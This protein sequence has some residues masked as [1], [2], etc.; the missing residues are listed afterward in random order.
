MTA[1]SI[2]PI[3]LLLLIL[4]GLFL[5]FYSIIGF[6]R[7][8]TKSQIKLPFIKTEISGPA[9]LVSLVVGVLMIASPILLAAFQKPDNVTSPPPPASVAQVQMI[10]EPSYKS[11]RFLRDMSL[12]DL[13]AI[14]VAP[15][16]T[17]LP[18]WKLLG[19]KERI[20]P[21]ILKNYMTVK[22]VDSVNYI[23]LTYAT[24][25]KLDVRCP[26]HQ[27]TFR[28]SERI[29]EGTLVETWEVIA[30]VST[31]PVG[32]EFEIV[33]EATYWN[34]FSGKDGDDYTT[35]GHDQAEPE[36]ISIIAFF[37]EDKPYKNVQMTEISPV[38]KI[39][40]P[41]QGL[42]ESWPGPQN[43]TFYWT[44]SSQRPNWYYKLAWKW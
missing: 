34:A 14:D 20:K 39:S 27:A 44:V 10:Q 1:N 42:T 22:K 5:F 29:E 8:N 16:Y 43:R 21:A 18:G 36:Q 40:G 32:Q 13:R 24:S 37:P 33:V 17:E 38:T 3:C 19:Q 30:D 25:G 23:H 28:R 6:A 11:F 26:T 9:W 41:V 7:R 35:Y 15:W 31:I 12:L 2:I 4:S